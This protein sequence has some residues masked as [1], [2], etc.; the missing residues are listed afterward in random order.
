MKEARI[1]QVLEI[2]AQFCK[3]PFSSQDAK[4]KTESALKRAAKRERNIAQEVDEWI[5]A[6]TGIFLSSDVVKELHLSSREDRKNLSKILS[7]RC[8]EGVIGRHGDKNGCFRRIDKNIEEMNFLVASTET[9]N[10]IL[11]F[12]I[13]EKIEIMPGNIVLIAGEINSGKT[14]FCL[15]IIKENMCRFDVHYFNSEMGGG[16][17]KKRLLKF[18]GIGLNVWKFRAYERS[19]NFAD[20]IVPGP[21]SINIIDF[22][23]IHENFYEIGAR[24]AEIHKKLKGAVAI[25]AI[26]KNKGVDI[27]LGGYRSLEKPRL[28]LA[29]KPGEIKI[30]KAKN[31]RTDENPNGLITEFKI[32]NGCNLYQSGVWHREV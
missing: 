13:H 32:V 28:A 30:V 6:T 11:P 14:A 25:I 10:L 22:L 4:A 20:V 18:D 8:E 3:P 7:R 24:I 16:E 17:L 5:M 23:E 29:I 2:L 26:Q 1:A 9:V 19:D 12:N 31:W 15:N 27:G 21:K